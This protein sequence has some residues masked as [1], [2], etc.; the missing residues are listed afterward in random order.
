MHPWIEAKIFE[1]VDVFLASP[2][3]PLDYQQVV[4][5]NGCFDLLHPGHIDYLMNS[6]DKGEMLIV[7]LNHDISIQKLKGEGRP[8]NSWRDRAAVLAGLACVDFVIGFSEETP[9]TVIKTIQPMV[10]T[11][12]GDYQLD[13]MIGKDFIE[14]YGGRVEIVPYLKGFS[15]SALLK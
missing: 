5:T 13:D 8:L 1:T 11:K 3:W 15:T 6:R 2:R 4:F 12:G 7:G 10:A 14:S 9:I